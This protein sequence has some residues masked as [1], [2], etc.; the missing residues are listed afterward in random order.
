MV[1]K[2]LR[3]ILIKI[4]RIIYWLIPSEFKENSNQKLNLKLKESVINETLHNFHEHFKKSVLFYDYLQLRKY[5]ITSSL[6]KSNGQECYFLELGVW[7]GNSANHFSKYV[8]KLHVFDSF[9]G[10][11]ED[12]VGNGYKPKGHFNLKKKIPKLNSNIEVHVGWVEDTLEPFL[13]KHN[14][15]ISFVHLDMDIYSPTKYALEKLKPYLIKDAIIL[16]DELYNYIGWENGEYKALKE[17][18]NDNEFEY[19]AF[20]MYSRQVLIKIK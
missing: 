5:A 15:K 13:K 1:K 11:S 14:P 18:F 8:K 2:T 10:L 19:K 6:S 20:N 17:V 4:S 7:K 3:F 12:W 9:E 16:F